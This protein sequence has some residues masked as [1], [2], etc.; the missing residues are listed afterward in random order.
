[1]AHAPVFW[2]VDLL[3]ANPPSRKTFDW[4]TSSSEKPNQPLDKPSGILLSRL[5]KLVSKINAKDQ[6][7][8]MKWY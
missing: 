4:V 2:M 1:M 6:A 8:R 5:T 7:T 3:T